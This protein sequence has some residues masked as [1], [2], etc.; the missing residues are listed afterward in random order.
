MVA[1]SSVLSSQNLWIDHIYYY[2]RSTIAISVSLV[3]LFYLSIR[4]QKREKKKKSNK[5]KDKI[6]YG[7]GVVP[8]IMVF[9]VFSSFVLN[10]TGQFRLRVRLLSPI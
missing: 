6:E 8:G 10:F 4:N 1:I 3:I 9:I 5:R 2:Y 7:A